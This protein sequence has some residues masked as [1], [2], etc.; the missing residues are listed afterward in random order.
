MLTGEID[1]LL[2]SVIAVWARSG[3]GLG[4]VKD[5]LDELA[6][7]VGRPEIASRRE[8][9]RY[10]SVRLGKMAYEGYGIDPGVGSASLPA[11]REWREAPE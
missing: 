5:R 6:A 11:G 10:D 7:R 1:F 2:S 3:V 4:E 8:R 9:I